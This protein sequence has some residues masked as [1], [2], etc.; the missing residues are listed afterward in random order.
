MKNKIGVKSEKNLHCA[1]SFKANNWFGKSGKNLVC[2]ACKCLNKLKSPNAGV[3][4]MIKLMTLMDAENRAHKPAI[5]MDRKGKC[6]RLVETPF[7]WDMTQLFR[8]QIIDKTKKRVA[9]TVEL[10]S[11]IWLKQSPVRVSVEA[12]NSNRNCPK[13]WNTVSNPSSIR[14]VFHY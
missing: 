11:K 8:L 1:L 6:S 9:S 4:Y 13:S 14:D 12:L 10:S 2:S 3:K 7:K 5:I